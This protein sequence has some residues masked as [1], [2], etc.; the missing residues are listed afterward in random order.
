M[1]HGPVFVFA[2]L[3]WLLADTYFFGF[4]FSAFVELLEDFMLSLL[5]IYR[6]EWADNG[7]GFDDGWDI[8]GSPI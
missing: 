5:G 4:V 1:N 2:R 7:W 6:L 8:A 3:A